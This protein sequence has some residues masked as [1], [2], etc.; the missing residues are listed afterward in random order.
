MRS[1][2]LLT[3]LLLVTASLAAQERTQSPHGKLSLECAACHRSDGWTPVQISK[4]FDHSKF[5]F[6][7]VGAHTTTNCRACRQGLD[8][9]GTS[10]TCASCHQDTHRGSWRWTAPAATPRAASLTA[11]RWPG[12]T[13][14]AAFRSRVRTW[15]RTAP[16]A[17]DPPDRDSSVSWG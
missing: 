9:K 8:F 5:G 17:I 7:L 4:K 14:R 10:T 11:A 3:S 16:I 6:P 12:R 15:R 1:L 2:Y 13:S